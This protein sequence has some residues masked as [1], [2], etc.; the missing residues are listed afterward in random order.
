MMAPAMLNP[1][2]VPAVAAPAATQN[3]A[4]ACAPPFGEVLS[5]ELAARGSPDAGGKR[6]STESRNPA[7]AK[8]AAGKSGQAND[9]D[10]DDSDAS[11]DHGVATTAAAQLLMLVANLAGVDAIPAEPA[12]ANAEAPLNAGQE[13]IARDVMESLTVPATASAAAAAALPDQKPGASLPATAATIQA[14]SEVKQPP[15][16]TAARG[17]AAQNDPAPLVNGT[18]SGLERRAAPAQHGQPGPSSTA[19]TLTGHAAVPAEM[20]AESTAGTPLL[21]ALRGAASAPE[22][23]ADPLLGRPPAL[24]QATFNNALQQ[25]ALNNVPAAT[26]PVADKLSLPVGTTGW[27]QAVGQK[28]V[29]MVAGAQSNAS[30][31][32]NPPDLGPLQVALSVVKDQ[33][34]VSFTA[35]LPEVRQAL[36]AALPKLR[37]MLADAGIQMGQ[38]SV[39]AGAPQQHGGQGESHRTPRGVDPAAAAIDAPLSITDSHPARGRQGLIDT[40]V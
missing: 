37:E 31:T 35:A 27:D 10:R 4:T 19:P 34:T 30:L 21:P 7:A 5:R 32:L 17:P 2:S 15:E 18:L 39:N 20:Q 26:A 24:E 14:D 33:A 12:P 3:A 9:I 38:A 16:L 22:M 36:E 1:A 28:V 29:W 40:F 8:T 6:C 13:Q 11:D 23:Q 25:A